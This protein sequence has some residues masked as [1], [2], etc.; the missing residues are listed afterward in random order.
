MKAKISL[1]LL[2][3]FLSSV[4]SY[5]DFVV[6]N[7][8]YE[9]INGTTARVTGGTINGSLVIPQ[10]VYDEDE[11]AE[12]TVTEIGDNAFSLWGGDGARISGSVTL[13]S[14]IKKIGDKA[15]YYQS[16]S[17]INF[18]EGLKSIGSYAFDVNR[19]L[20]VVTL[21]STLESLG[22]GA[23]Q[24]CGLNQVFVMGDKP[25]TL[26]TDAFLDNAYLNIIVRP[27]TYET[28]QKAWSTY[29]DYVTDIFPLFITGEIPVYD[30][31]GDNGL[32][33]PTAN[34]NTYCSPVAIAFEKSPELTVWTVDS[35]GSNQVYTS[36]ITSGIIP[37]GEG[38]ILKSDADTIFV[39]MAENQNAVLGHGNLLKGVLHNTGLKTTD[40]DNVNYVLNDNVFT[41]FDDS[42]QW[43]SYI[44]ANHAYLQVP[45]TV[46][47][48]SAA[49]VF[50]H[51]STAIS[52]IVNTKAKE[53]NAY[54]NLQG[55]KISSK[56]ATGMYIY[57]GKKYLAK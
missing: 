32:R 37:A 44:E 4:S 36:S 13:P 11:D 46:E 50:G 51:T 45:S 41:R 30:L 34:Y 20:Q 8:K 52:N 18:P 17:S 53:D 49:I 28:Y 42:D 15:F 24:R 57:H 55:M 40:G 6:D 22:N 21:P 38:V 23:F 25:A 26:G 12:Y 10:T 2:G 56:P 3:M 43:R 14:T 29:S 1:L 9:A 48:D 39:Q 54:Y 27:S 35:V 19:N 31:W 5:A 16:F 33:T 7:I 47:L